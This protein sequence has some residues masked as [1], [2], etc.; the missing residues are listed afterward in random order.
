LASIPYFLVLLAEVNDAVAVYLAAVLEYVCA[1][2]LELGFVATRFPATRDQ[3]DLLTM[4]AQ[5]EMPVV[6]ITRNV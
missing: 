2:V 3:V 5:L 6:T 4:E 1:E